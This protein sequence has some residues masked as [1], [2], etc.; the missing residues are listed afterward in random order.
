MANSQFSGILK[1]DAFRIHTC[2]HSEPYFETLEKP[3]TRRLRVIARIDQPLLQYDDGGPHTFA[4]TAQT[5]C[6][7]FTVWDPSTYSP[8]LEPWDFHTFPKCKQLKRTSVCVGQLSPDS[9]AVV[10]TR[11]N[12]LDL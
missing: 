1:L 2:W 10:I 5:R 7:G 12:T 4:R 8:S 11:Q 3:K 9:G 6:L